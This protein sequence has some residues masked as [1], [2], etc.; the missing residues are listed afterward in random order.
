MMSDF[1]KK[2]NN[3]YLNERMN[4]MKK[5]IDRLSNQTK[6]EKSRSDTFIFKSG[7]KRKVIV[8]D[9]DTS[10]PPK[11]TM[12]TIDFRS[13]QLDNIPTTSSLHVKRINDQFHQDSIISSNNNVHIHQSFSHTGIPITSKTHQQNVSS[14]S[15]TA[16][17]TL[18]TNRP[19]I[20]CVRN[21]FPTNGNHSQFEHQKRE[22]I[23]LSKMS[24]LF[25]DDSELSN[26]NEESMIKGFHPYRRFK[27]DGKKH[28]LLPPM[29][30]TPNPLSFTGLKEMSEISSS[31]FSFHINSLGSHILPSTYMSFDGLPHKNSSND[32]DN[33][34]VDYFHRKI[35]GM[36]K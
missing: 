18:S 2:K 11:R 36:D 24:A 16:T 5:N 4:H 20:N 31:N 29:I 34:F 19:P 1:M 14:F 21:Q 35:T 10:L 8:D 27:N 26:V 13:K 15:S 3:I 23:D 9:N 7:E 17:I 6:S 22:P 25:K 30:T 32:S 33:L 12:T 28:A